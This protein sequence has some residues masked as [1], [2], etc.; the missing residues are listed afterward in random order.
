MNTTK[1]AFI[2]EKIL[3]KVTNGLAQYTKKAATFT[4]TIFS[5]EN[6][7]LLVGGN[8]I[9]F[10]PGLEQWIVKKDGE[11]MVMNTENL[12]YCLTAVSV[13]LFYQS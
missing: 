7:L 12:I 5:F 9:E 2:A 13:A 3:P 10:A 1:Q 11:F 4:R 8:E 6:N